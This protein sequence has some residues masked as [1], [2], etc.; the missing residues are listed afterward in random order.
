MILL[1][2]GL[3]LG[4][5][6]S[7][8]S[9]VAPLPGNR[10]KESLAPLPSAAAPG[11]PPEGQRIDA[12]EI[13]DQAKAAV[14][15]L[16]LS[17]SESTY[18]EFRIER[19]SLVFTC[20][21]SPGATDRELPLLAC[22]FGEFVN[23]V[24]GH[25]LLWR[26]GGEWHAQLYPE[27]PPDVTQKRHAYYRTLGANC[28]VGCGSEF[29]ALRQSGREL[30][31]VVDL[32]GVSTRRNQEVHLLRR[33]GQ[34]WQILWL[35]DPHALRFAETPPFTRHPKITLPTEGAGGF[36]VSFDDGSSHTWVRKGTEYV[37]SD[38]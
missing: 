3:L 10:E 29:K 25:A 8:R 18:K 6:T 9:Q 26:D 21:Y 30:L 28:P 12:G 15:A 5:C 33:E 34:Q 16:N 2:L 4:A 31:A 35:P 1:S 38:P 22:K 14:T 27:A 17:G 24:A 20:Q 36:I 11:V 32:S 23:T 13:L 37:R 19:P 7:G